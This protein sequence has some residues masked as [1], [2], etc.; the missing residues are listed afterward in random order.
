[1]KLMDLDNERLR[2]K[3]FE[4]EKRKGQNKLTSGH[5]QHMT[6]NDNLDLLAQQD[7]ES[8]MK[9]VFKEAAP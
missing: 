3:V 7:W 5:A 8:G 9:Y 2:K 1:M 6:A 4:K